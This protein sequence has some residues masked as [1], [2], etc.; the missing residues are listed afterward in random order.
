[1]AHAFRYRFHRHYAGACGPNLFPRNQ[2]AQMMMIEV[3]GLQDELLIFDEC[4]F[5]SESPA[6]LLFDPGTYFQ[7]KGTDVWTLD[8]FE[9]LKKRRKMERQRASVT[10]A[11]ERLRLR[12]RPGTEAGHRAHRNCAKHLPR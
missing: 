10:G 2:K 1:M 6:M 9:H 8:W 5:A 11:V 7:W 3:L 4:R 12:S